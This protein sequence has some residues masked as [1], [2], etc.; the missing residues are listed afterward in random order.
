MV[1]N[2]I[3]AQK[4]SELC[5]RLL[6]AEGVPSQD[7][8]FVAS[9]LVEAD[10]RG[11]HSHGV[12]RLGRYV[13]E[14]G[15]GLTNVN[16]TIAVLDEGAAYAR[17]DGDGGLGPLVGRRG[18]GLAID[19]ARTA[20]SATVTACRSRH[21]GAAGFFSLMASQQDLIGIS[22]TVASSRLAP[23][24]GLKPLFGNNPLAMAV[25]GDQ[26]FPLVVDFAAGNIAA[27]KLELAAADDQPIAEGLARDSEGHPTTDPKV[28][29]KGSIV[30][31]GEHKGYGLTVFI[32]LLAGLLSGAPHFAVERDQIADHMHTKG[33]GH[34]FMAI[35]PARFMP[36]EQFKASVAHM[37]AITK[38]SPA[39][40]GTDEILLP[41]EKEARC[42]SERLQN[43]IP[44]VPSTLA[45]LASLAQQRD[46]DF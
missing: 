28:A 16:P 5:T 39:L 8:A 30:P 1:E 34:C 40:P 11:V 42:R 10:L 15:S 37:V 12:L 25:P 13:R 17:I 36:L 4:L 20:G 23:T 32:E 38:S 26:D 35:D 33:I 44:L 31:I 14:L 41:G 46:I 27:G 18:M 21:F 6:E 29:L 2:P 9:T 22:M 19:K 24:G 7:A 3:S 45:M 43:G